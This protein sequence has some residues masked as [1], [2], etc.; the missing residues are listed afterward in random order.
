ME[1]AE[2]C[3]CFGKVKLNSELKYLFDVL[4]YLFQ[5]SSLEFG[6]IKRKWIIELKRGKLGA[7]LMNSFKQYLLNLGQP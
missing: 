2:H 7:L 5:S 3:Y 6:Q 1:H 4:Q